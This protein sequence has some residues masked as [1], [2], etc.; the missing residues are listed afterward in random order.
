MT[1]RPTPATLW[2]PNGKRV[3]ITVAAG[4]SDDTSGAAG[5]LLTAAPP[6]AVDFDVGTPD[7]SG[8]LAARRSGNGDDNTYT[9]NYSGRDLAGN[10]G[11]CAATVVVPHDQSNH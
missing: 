8:L 3:P 7:V 2:P 4:L 11:N 10:T 5:L 9:L 1:C 6:D